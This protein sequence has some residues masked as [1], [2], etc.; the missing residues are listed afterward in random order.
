MWVERDWHCPVVVEARV[1]TPADHTALRDPAS[2]EQARLVSSVAVTPSTTERLAPHP[3]ASAA[4]SAYASSRGTTR[5]HYPQP[6]G[7]SPGEPGRDRQ[8]DAGGRGAAPRRP[9]ATHW[10]EAECTPD[11][12]SRAAPPPGRRHAQAAFW[13]TFRVIRAVSE[14]E[15]HGRPRRD[16]RLRLGDPLRRAGALDARARQEQRRRGPQ[17][18]PRPNCVIYPGELCPSLSLF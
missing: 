17:Q 16:E 1:L 12:S 8:V 3:A 14:V 18:T 9:P 5:G 4:N 13:S 2:G 11:R 15:C 10:P 6:P 7:R